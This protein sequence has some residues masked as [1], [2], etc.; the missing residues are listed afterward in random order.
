MVVS[1]FSTSNLC[2]S[3]RVCFCFSD[4]KIVINMALPGLKAQIKILVQS[5]LHEGMLD[6]Q[7]TQ[8][9]E[10]QDSNNPNFVAEI[11]KLFCDNT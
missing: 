5:M 6:Y 7:F 11:I 8:L 2:F 3:I 10:L 4:S 1:L 9:Q